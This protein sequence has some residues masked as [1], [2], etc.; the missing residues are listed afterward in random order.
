[1]Q[2]GQLF[3][4]AANELAFD[5]HLTHDVNSEG[6]LAVVAAMRSAD[7]HSMHEQARAAG[8]K[9]SQVVPVAMGSALL[10]HSINYQSAAVVH[11]T[12]EGLAVD[13]IADGELRYS[14]VASMPANSIGIEGEVSRTFAAAVL[15]CSPT[16]AAGALVLPDAEAS[17]NT[18]ALQE[19]ATRTIDVNIETAEQIYKRER[20]GEVQRLRTAI[21]AMGAALI[22]FVYQYNRYTA[23]LQTAN[24]GEAKWNKQYTRLRRLAEAQT[25]KGAGLQK[26]AK[27]L[28]RS[29]HPAQGFSDAFTLASNAAPQGVWLTGMSLER[30]KMLTIRGTATKGEAVPNYQQ[31]LVNEPRFRDVTLVFANN[32]EISNT[33]VVQFSISAFPIGNLPLL[34]DKKGAKK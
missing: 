11:R 20:S 21:M 28:N 4:M 17:T 9:V 34:D 10:A 15:S 14:R 31:A 26:L 13:L 24:S 7:L 25:A 27:T 23:S 16:I 3:P 30:G 8:L 29:F 1:M 5:F 2:I 12:A 6:K 33:P 22:L 19:L 32:T 18:W